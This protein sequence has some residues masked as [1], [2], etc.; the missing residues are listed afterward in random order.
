MWNVLLPLRFVRVRF[1]NSF[2]F[3]GFPRPAYCV[4]IVSWRRQCLDCPC[5]TFCA[6]VSWVGVGVLIDSFVLPFGRVY[7]PPLHPPLNLVRTHRP[8]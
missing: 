7:A 3:V 6:C 5:L 4:F 1:T 2:F 8:V